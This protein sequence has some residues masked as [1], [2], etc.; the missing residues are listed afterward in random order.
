MSS[1]NWPDKY[2]SRKE[3]TWD[4]SATPGHRV[5]VVSNQWVGAWEEK[6]AG[7]WGAE[8]T[9]PCHCVSWQVDS[10]RSC[11]GYSEEGIPGGCPWP[12]KGQKDSEDMRLGWG[13]LEETPADNNCG[14][15]LSCPYPS[16]WATLLGPPLH[17]VVAPLWGKNIRPVLQQ[18]MHWIPV[19][20]GSSTE[21]LPIQCARQGSQQERVCEV[22]RWK[23]LSCTQVRQQS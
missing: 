20:S 12:T 6:W 13:R 19:L 3:C 7:L 5:K 10:H 21:E 22:C 9:F 2:P 4:I 16:L 1:P 8:L 17:K 23:L 18:P 11:I 15:L 14:V